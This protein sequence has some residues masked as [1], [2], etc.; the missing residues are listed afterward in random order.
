MKKEWYESKSVDTKLEVLE[1][2]GLVQDVEVVKSSL[3]TF[4]FNTSPPTDSVATADVH[5]LSIVMGD[6]AATR[7]LLWDHVKNNWDIVSTKMGNPIVMDRFVGRTF[8]HFVDV[9]KVEELRAFFSDKDTKAYNRSLNTVFDHITA[10]AAY[11]ERGS[12]I[13]R[14]WLA[15]NG[16]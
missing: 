16:Y 1:T 6:N 11:R 13:L 15:S 10:R 4:L 2:L 3:L 9:A 7:D 8:Q 12:A 5:L 14:E